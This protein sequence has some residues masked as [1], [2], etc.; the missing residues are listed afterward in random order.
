MDQ[1]LEA[2]LYAQLLL[3]LK[4]RKKKRLDWITLAKSC[5]LLAD[6]HKSYAEL[7][8]KLGVSAHTV[9]SIIRLLD[10]PREVQEMIRK[11]EILQDAAYRL[12][13]I[14]DPRKQLAVA[15][16]IRNLPSHA[17]RE[18]IQHAK[19]IPGSDTAAFRDRVTQK[20]PAPERIHVLMCRL[21]E[22][23][24]SALLEYSRNNLTTPESVLAEAV[25]AR[26]AGR[27]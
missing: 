24:Y 13:A 17:Q 8:E 11:G 7:A 6:Q 1:D 25:R 4:G 5:K 14:H 19:R 20:I 16:K 22:K 2:K 3:D 27:L 26:L 18:V 21:T 9:R 10:L 23:E 12:N 15:R